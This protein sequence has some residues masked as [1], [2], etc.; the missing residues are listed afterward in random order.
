MSQAEQFLQNAMVSREQWG[1][2]RQVVAERF[3]ADMA[4]ILQ[5]DFEY[6]SRTRGITLRGSHREVSSNVDL[7]LEHLRNRLY[8]HIDAAHESLRED[9]WK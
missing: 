2:D 5:S 9:G 4:G 7:V 8:E 1:K 3:V 6:Q